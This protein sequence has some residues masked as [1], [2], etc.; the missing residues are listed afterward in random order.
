[1]T[2]TS[3]RTLTIV[4][5]SLASIPL[6]AQVNDLGGSTPYVAPAKKDGDPKPVTKP[7]SSTAKKDSMP[8]P[9]FKP[10]WNFSTWIFGAYN[11]IN[12]SL[13]KAANSGQANS[14]FTVDRAYLTFRGLVAPDWGFRVTTDVVTLGAGAG[15]NGLILRLKYAWM[16]WDYLHA[17]QPSDWSAW[18]RIGQVTTIEI[19]DEERFWPRWIQK[20]PLEYWAIQPASSDLGAGTQVNLPNRW[21]NVYFLLSNGGGYTVASDA[22]RFKDASLRL[23]LWPLGRSDGMFKNLELN[24]WYDAGRTQAAIVTAPPNIKPG[25]TNNSYGIFLGSADPRFSF[26]IDWANRTAQ[27][28][29]PADSTR[30]SNSMDLFAGYIVVRPFLFNDAHGTPLGIIL[31]YDNFKPYGDAFFPPAGLTTST[32]QDLFIATLFWDVAKQS[33]LGISYQGQTQSSPSGALYEKTMY[34]LNYQVTF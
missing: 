7:D 20:T 8:K 32:K 9:E 3:L 33:S 27:T 1:M 12:D 17:E 29:N 6:A 4:L 19:D 16:E 2:R 24:G 15:Y 26:G 18:A 14:K 23:S 11:Y 21:G 31:R 25:L 13:T 10:S 5:A 22:D 30:H 28:I 34:Q